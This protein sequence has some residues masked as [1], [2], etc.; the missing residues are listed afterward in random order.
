MNIAR[1][2]AGLLFFLA[3]LQWLVLVFIAESFFPN[4]SV[5]ANTLSDLAATVAPNTGVVEPSA[6][7]FN[8]AMMGLGGAIIASGLLLQLSYRKKYFTF[9]AVVFGAACTLV[10]VFPP[11]TGAIHDTIA[12]VAFI[13]GPLTAIA[14]YQ[15][16]R[17]LLRYLS[18]A[19]GLGALVPVTMHLVLGDASPIRA[20]MGPG[21]EERLIVYPLLVWVTG[22]GGY[23]IGPPPEAEE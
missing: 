22:F 6:G 5:N 1:R 17:G 4:Y 16:E 20:L 10:G 13:F 3:G 23:L 14:A 11:D 2:F 12:L 9:F 18:V 19:I 15:M 8:A 21:G 7:L